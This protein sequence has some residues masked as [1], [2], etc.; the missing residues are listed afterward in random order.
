MILIDSSTGSKDLVRYPPLNDPSIACLTSL[1]V[2]SDS[3]SSVDVCFTGNGPD[4]PL[5]IGIEFKSLSDLLSSIYSGRFQATQSQSMTSEY[6]ICW[7]LYYGGYRCDPDG[8]LETPYVNRY[9]KECWSQYTFVGNKPM[10]YGYL[11]SS[12]LTY[13]AVGIQS[14]HVYCGTGKVEI[15]SAIQQCANWISCLYRW[16]QKPWDKHKSLR[17]FDKSSDK[18]LAMP[19]L[20]PVSRDILSHAKE[21]PGMGFE[22]G[23]AAAKHF[24]SVWE[25]FNADVSEWVK[26]DGIGKVIARS[27]VETIRRQKGTNTN[28]KQS[29][30]PSV[31]KD[32]L[33]LDVF[34]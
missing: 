14:K 12:L 5:T 3:K 16:W 32:A 2:S 9:G 10:P 7:L 18:S 17:T 33:N 8:Y 25:M 26:I 15:E 29:S 6:Q 34:K 24:S 19:H 11:E 28:V 30:I 23:L 4:G 27:A 22:R 20:D 21:L 31:T 1:A 13:S